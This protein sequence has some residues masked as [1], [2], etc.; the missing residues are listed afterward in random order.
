MCAMFSFVRLLLSRAQADHSTRLSLEKIFYPE[1]LNCRTAVFA[2][3]REHVDRFPFV[4][5]RTTLFPI[6]NKC[7]ILKLHTAKLCPLLALPV[8][9]CGTSRALH[10][11]SI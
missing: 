5:K 8:H 1:F 7:S 11:L 9:I 6:Q 3:E 10:I 4:A 2:T